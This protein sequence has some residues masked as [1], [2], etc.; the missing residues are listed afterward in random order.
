MMFMKD[1]CFDGVFHVSFASTLRFNV[2]TQYFY[3]LY[4][5][6]WHVKLYHENLAPTSLNLVKHLGRGF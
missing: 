5:G 2:F 1:F 6:F 4:E 3:I